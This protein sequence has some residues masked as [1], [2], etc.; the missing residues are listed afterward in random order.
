MHKQCGVC[1]HFCTMWYM[2][3]PVGGLCTHMCPYVVWFACVC[4][5]VF[6]RMTWQDTKTDTVLVSVHPDIDWVSSELGLARLFHDFPLSMLNHLS[7]QAVL[8]S[9]GCLRCPL[10]N[11]HETLTT[12]PAGRCGPSL[13]RLVTDWSWMCGWRGAAFAQCHHKYKSFRVAALGGGGAEIEGL[14]VQAWATY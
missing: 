10:P 9:P 7:W 14:Q 2:C 3:F 13:Y 4:L 11:L 6:L 1:A 8:S 5:Y 12:V